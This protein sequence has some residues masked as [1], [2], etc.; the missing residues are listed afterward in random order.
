MNKLTVAIDGP[1]GA[2][3]STVAQIVAQRLHY[4]YI[5]TG[6]MYRALTWKVLQKNLRLNNRSEI[7]K[8]AE[9]INLRLDYSEGKTRV[10]V[11]EQDI[12]TDVRTPVVTGM[13]AE[14]AQIPEVRNS[15]ILLQ[16]EMAKSGGV[17][18]DGRD[19]CTHVLPD[20][21]VKIF[22]TASIEERAKRRWLELK[23]KGMDVALE[24]IR[25]DIVCR[26]KKDCEREI[27]PL[28]KAPDAVLIDSTEMSIEEAVQQILF[29]CQERKRN[30]ITFSK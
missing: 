21:E 24:T 1:A 26:D 19:I 16:R 25:T 5:D 13:V 11:D 15:M 3:K 22:L 23:N 20:A 12:T 9:N 14:I 18:V 17:V 28:I 6:A 30:C 7:I 10:F 8:I 2:G 29:I 4:T 27:A